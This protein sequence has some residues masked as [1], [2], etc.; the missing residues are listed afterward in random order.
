MMKLNGLIEMGILKIVEEIT[1]LATTQMFFL[2]T[3]PSVKTLTAMDMAITQQ[4]TTAMRS[5]L[6]Q[7]SGRILMAMVLEITTELVR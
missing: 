3:P 6:T 5:S 2:M 1:K 7:H 4:E